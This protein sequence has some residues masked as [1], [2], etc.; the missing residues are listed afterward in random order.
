M[1]GKKRKMR[2]LAVLVLC[3]AFV[4]NACGKE[5]S[6]TSGAEIMGRISAISNSE[7][8]LEVFQQ[9]DS[10]D[11]KP[12]RP[13]E[14]SGEKPPVSGGAFRKGEKPPVSGG[15]VQRGERESKTYLLTE[16]TK[17][18]E[19]NGEDTSEISLE[20]V[21]L[22]SAASV[23]LDSDGK[24]AISVILQKRQQGNIPRGGKSSNGETT[25]ESR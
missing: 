19:K 7:I 5:S 12:E 14:A 21:E 17:F 18:Y 3:V 16:D 4:L 22:G 11:S 25:T 24:T 23:V 15:A 9:S 20:E 10:S 13:D 8:T 2:I 6:E 1:K